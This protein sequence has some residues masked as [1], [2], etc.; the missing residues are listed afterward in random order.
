MKLEQF[1]LEIEYILKVFHTIYKKFLTIID[2][3][4]Y[5]PSQKQNTTRVKRSEIYS[6]YGHYSTQ[7][8]KLTPSEEE[9]LD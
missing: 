5:H 2:H 3:I 7:T 4:D 1:Q 6:S 8:Q 9:F